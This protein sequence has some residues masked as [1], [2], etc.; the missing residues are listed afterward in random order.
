MA[1]WTQSDIDRLKAMIAS[2]AKETTFVSGDTSRKVVL[3]SLSDMRRLLDDMISEVSASS[4]PP[5]V[6][7]T[8]YSRD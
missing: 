6:I 5:R 4:Q 8:E 2:G 7:I 1:I 3:H